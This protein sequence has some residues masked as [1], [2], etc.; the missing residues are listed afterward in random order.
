MRK[1]LEKA[2]LEQLS[3]KYPTVFSEEIGE[4]RGF[5]H[6]IKLKPGTMP[7]QT[8]MRRVP[9][10]KEKAYRRR[11]DELLRIGELWRKFPGGKSEWNSP[12]HCI[13]KP[14]GKSVQSDGGLLTDDQPLHHP[15]STPI[16]V[17]C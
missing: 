3:Q 6:M 2:L 17:A 1:I 16:A 9:Y 8:A 5:E 15:N 10:A 12:M 4:M 13:S 14:D 7:V 11:T